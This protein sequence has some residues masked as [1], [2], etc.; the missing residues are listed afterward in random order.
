MILERKMPYLSNI[1]IY[2][3]YLSSAVKSL[4]VL[5]MVTN[6]CG[7]QSWVDTACKKRTGQKILHWKCH[8]RSSLNIFQ[9][10]MRN[11]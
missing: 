7:Q 11:E 4:I 1:N 10:S 3:V 2:L 8:Q 9:V 5:T 6:M